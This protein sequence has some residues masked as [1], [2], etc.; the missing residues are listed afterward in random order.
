MI[1]DAKISLEINFSGE[2]NMVLDTSSVDIH[3]QVICLSSL[4]NQGRKIAACR[5]L[6]L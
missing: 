6:L 2:F 3:I 5:A 4:H 1:E